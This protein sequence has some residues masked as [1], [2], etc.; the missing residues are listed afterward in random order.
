M[1]PPPGGHQGHRSRAACLGAERE[2]TCPGLTL[3]PRG[4]TCVH[5]RAS[6]TGTS[7]LPRGL[8]NPV[9]GGQASVYEWGR[10]DTTFRSVVVTG[11]ARSSPV[12]AVWFFLLLPCPSRES[13]GPVAFNTGDSRSPWALRLA[14]P[15]GTS[16]RAAVALTG[17][18]G[19][20][21]GPP[22]RRPSDHSYSG[23]RTF[24]STNSVTCRFTQPHWTPLVPLSW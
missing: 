21:H 20:R 16:C 10:G 17:G 9:T 15:R 14:S 18:G 5:H 3:P 7:F 23:G 19:H 1:I 22:L 2:R 11:L 24:C 8:P 13:L 12:S 6:F 4:S